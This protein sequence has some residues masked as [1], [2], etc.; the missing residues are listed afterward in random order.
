M[1]IQVLKS[2]IADL[3]SIMAPMIKMST[4]D[5]VDS[6]EK[7]M[8][9]ILEALLEGSLTAW[10]AYGKDET[11]LYG[12]ITTHFTYDPFGG[13]KSLGIYT[14]YGFNNM[15]KEIWSE[16]IQTILEYAMINKCKNITGLTD[17]DNI[18][19]IAQKL[20]ANIDTTLII[21]EL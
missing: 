14:L 5:W 9:N 7:N 16:G 3:W 2:K 17:I 18:K 1:L 6:D 21:W 15:P 20:G 13:S 19:S 12:L 11:D 10:F 8:V 4:P